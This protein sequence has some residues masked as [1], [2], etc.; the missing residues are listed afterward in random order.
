MLCFHS[1]PADAE[2]LLEKLLQFFDDGLLLFGAGTAAAKTGDGRHQLVDVG[3]GGFDFPGPE[4]VLQELAGLQLTELLFLDQLYQGLFPLCA[5]IAVPLGHHVVHLVDTRDKVFD[6]LLFAAQLGAGIHGTADG[7]EHFLV[8]AVGIVV[9]LHQHEDVIDVDLDLADE[10][11][12][13]DDVVGDVLLVAMAPL[14]PLIPQVLVPAQI[15]LQ[16]PLVQQFLLGKLIEGGE[17][18]AH[19]KNGAEQSDECLLVLFSLNARV[20]QRELGGQFLDHIHVAGL[21][22]AVSGG[23][24]VV[25]IPELAQQHDAAGVFVAKE[26][27]GR[28][29]PLLQVAET[30]DV[31]EGLD[32]I[33][34]AVG[35]AERLD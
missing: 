10:F 6:Q 20:G 5:D 18:V 34:N 7:N 22:P 26:G 3:A 28:I 19:S 24:A 13:K 32:R 11:H 29:H 14:Q 9:L 27:D 15:V 12:L 4:G 16:I 35:A 33:Q 1:I 2:E 31:A 21:F 23:I 8:V 30:D 25:V 17:Q